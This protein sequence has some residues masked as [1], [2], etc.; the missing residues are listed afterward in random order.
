MDIFETAS[1]KKF[2]YD[3]AKGALT[4]EQLWDLPLTGGATNL[5]A[6]ARS[7]NAELKSVTEDSFVEIK[8]DP[9]K[10]TIA[11]ALDVVKHIIAV[12]MKAAEDAKAAVARADKRRKLLEA[13]ESK[14]DQ[15]LSAMSKEDILKKL[16]ELDA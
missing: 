11:T 9:R 6:I 5:D 2:R 13:L 12:K 8:P 4:T 16:E 14:E 3:S 7:V 15:A 1:R 10:E